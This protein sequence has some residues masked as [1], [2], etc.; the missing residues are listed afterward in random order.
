MN[1]FAGYSSRPSF[2]CS[3]KEDT[4]TLP[5]SPS[6]KTPV[7]RRDSKNSYN[8]AIYSL[9]SLFFTLRLI[10]RNII[11]ISYPIFFLLSLGDVTAHVRVQ[12]WPSRERLG[13]RLISHDASLIKLPINARDPISSHQ[14]NRDATCFADKTFC[15]FA[16]SIYLR[17]SVY[18]FKY[19]YC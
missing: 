11:I 14:F 7:S 6:V 3:V 9:I 15:T 1:D 12:D 5:N 18:Y 8:C 19:I 13:T 16:V 10:P 17:F 4:K 2:L